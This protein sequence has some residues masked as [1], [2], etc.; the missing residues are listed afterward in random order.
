M[1]YL[2][3]IPNEGADFT[4]FVVEYSNN[5][6]LQK[7][8]IKILQER[9][10]YDSE[11][12]KELIVEK[13]QTAL[14]KEELLLEHLVVTGTPQNIIVKILQRYLDKVEIDNELI[15]VDPYLYPSRHPANYSQFVIDILSKYLPTIT[16]LRLV[17]ASNY[18]RTIKTQIET[19]L[20]NL[21]P[22]LRISHQTSDDYHDRYWISKGREKG[23]IIGT[24]LNGLGNKYSLVDRLNTTDVRQIVSG[25]VTDGLI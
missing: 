5:P 23:I 24:S 6:I 7:F 17:T 8:D 25:L 12:I 18:N 16:D 14:L 22:G 19:D 2:K 3:V 15:I 10:L 9:H 4:D 11:S 13:G 1:I 21:R 20:Q